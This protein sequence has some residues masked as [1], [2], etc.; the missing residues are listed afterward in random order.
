MV[1]D[2]HRSRLHLWRE[3]LHRFEDGVDEQE[4]VE[5]HEADEF[6]ELLRRHICQSRLV[7]PLLEKNQRH[8]VERV[9][10]DVDGEKCIDEHLFRL[11]QLLAG[12]KVA[13]ECAANIKGDCDGD[14][15]GKVAANLKQMYKVL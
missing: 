14:A 6:G 7:S 1:D 5:R 8:D 15:K 4:S 13:V 3:Q 9:E 11:V 12:F 2:E 10:K